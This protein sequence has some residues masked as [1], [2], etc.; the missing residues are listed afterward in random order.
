MFVTT[1]VT[2]HIW[3]LNIAPMY[4]TSQT[5]PIASSIVDKIPGNF[6]GDIF[7]FWASSWF[8]S[9]G[10]LPAPKDWLL[11]DDEGGVGVFWYTKLQ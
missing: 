2:A 3:R 8:I 10:V 5:L 9:A 1:H 11:C 4:D 7:A 6:R